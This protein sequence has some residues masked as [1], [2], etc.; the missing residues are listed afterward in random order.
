MNADLKTADHQCTDSPFKNNQTGECRSAKAFSQ[1]VWPPASSA[2]R[3]PL[4]AACPW[5]GSHRR[6]GLLF[7][8]S[9]SPWQ[10]SWANLVENQEPLTHPDFA[11]SQVHG[12]AWNLEALELLLQ[13]RG[14]MWLIWNTVIPSALLW[15]SNIDSSSPTG[16]EE[17][18]VWKKCHTHQE[19]TVKLTFESVLFSF[20]K[21][22]K[23]IPKK[24][25]EIIMKHKLLLILFMITIMFWRGLIL[26]LPNTRLRYSQ[27]AFSRTIPLNLA[28]TL[29]L[30]MLFCS[31]LVFFLPCW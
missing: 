9:V 8:D 25:T 10:R 12:H 19:V 18:K 21:W 3:P 26:H 11:R 15:H 29:L 31:S 22:N 6:T 14:K 30:Q 7:S 5:S 28:E 4:R 17:Q 1:V 20:P 13:T 16:S 23:K 2:P 24:H 27:N